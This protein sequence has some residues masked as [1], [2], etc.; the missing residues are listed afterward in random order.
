MSNDKLLTREKFKDEVFKRDNNSCVVCKNSAK[1]AH[2]IIERRLW[3]DGGYYLSNGVSLCELHHLEAESTSL[4]AESLRA[5][6]KI[7]KTLL[8][9]HLYKDNNYD[10]W[11]NIILPNGNR[12]RGE[13]F[14]DQSVQK[15]LDP[16]IKK[17]FIKYI[18]YPRTFHIPH[19]QGVLSDDKVLSD[20]SIFENKVVVITEKLDGENSTIYNDYFHARSIDS[21]SHP[22]QAWVRNFAASVGAQLPE[23]YRLCG[24]NLYA[25]HSIVYNELETYFYGF[26]I[27]DD[28]NRCLS[29]EETLLWFSLLGITP[30]KTL[31]RGL[32]SI[33]KLEEII[34]NLNTAK[35]E[36]FVIRLEDSFP[37]SDFKQSVGK[38]VRKNHVT[39]QTHWGFR[40]DNRNIN[41]LKK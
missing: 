19:S 24:E 6:A 15:I 21:S 12:V 10:K 35:Q 9:P 31:Y 1:D 26:S 7:E 37:Y 8:P 34:K 16:E 23:N 27:W 28:L 40:W 41:T 29:W 14:F 4:S 22:S 11:G 36:G 5:F 30:V 33:E 38:Y 20:Y 39:A 32:F 17:L 18:K 3:P 2:H 25:T 13:L